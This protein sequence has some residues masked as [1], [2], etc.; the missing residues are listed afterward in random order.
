MAILAKLNYRIKTTL[1]F[2]AVFK[3]IERV[4]PKIHMGMEETQNSQNNTKI[5]QN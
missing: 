3:N 4:D 2:S 5:E 1:N